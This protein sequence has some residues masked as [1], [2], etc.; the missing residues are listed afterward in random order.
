[1]SKHY[2]SSRVPLKRP[3]KSWGAWRKASV[4]DVHESSLVPNSHST[5]CILCGDT[6]A[7][8]LASSFLLSDTLEEL[9]VSVQVVPGHACQGAAAAVSSVGQQKSVLFLF[10]VQALFFSAAS[11]EESFPLE[12]TQ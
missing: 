3:S 7:A 10:R 6:S 2:G 1:M 12:I 9:W 4:F 11:C 5:A 8:Q